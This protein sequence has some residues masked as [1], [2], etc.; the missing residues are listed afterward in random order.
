MDVQMPAPLLDHQ[1]LK[2]MID[3]QRLKGMAPSQRVN[4]LTND[5]LC[6]FDKPK[7]NAHSLSLLAGCFGPLILS[8]I[9]QVF[10]MAFKAVGACNSNTTESVRAAVVQALTNCELLGSAGVIDIQLAGQAK[11][12]TE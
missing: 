5:R 8:G 9:I 10:I 6:C 7:T 2:G 1:R 12:C 3:R 4:C 11:S